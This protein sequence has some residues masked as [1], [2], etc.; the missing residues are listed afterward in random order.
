M[1]QISILF[2]MSIQFQINERQQWVFLSQQKITQISPARP[3]ARS[4][5]LSPTPHSGG[6][7][8]FLL[9]FLFFLQE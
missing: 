4:V 2:Q 6:F 5:Y 8:L 1:F 7:L 9:F 3:N